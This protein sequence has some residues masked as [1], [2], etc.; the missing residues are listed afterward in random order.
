MEFIILPNKRGKTAEF[1]KERNEKKKL[2]FLT[3][4]VQF[5]QKSRQKPLHRIKSTPKVLKLTRYAHTISHEFLRKE[6]NQGNSHSA[7]TPGRGGKVHWVKDR[8]QQI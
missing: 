2:F 4:F 3:G 6:K 8:H 5:T 7:E 1:D